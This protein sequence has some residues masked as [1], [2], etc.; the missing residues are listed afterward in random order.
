M[1]QSRVFILQVHNGAGLYTIHVDILAVRLFV[2]VVRYLTNL[3]GVTEREC[4]LQ[5]P[6]E[7]YLG[8]LRACGG[9]SGNPTVRASLESAQSLK[10]AGHATSSWELQQKR[11]LFQGQEI[12]DET[13]LRGGRRKDACMQ[14]LFYVY[15][16]CP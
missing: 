2:E 3:P 7:N 16:L 11:R 14:T 8:Q 1:R 10:V 6:L 9:R 12:V 5:D 4:F 13:P 15:T